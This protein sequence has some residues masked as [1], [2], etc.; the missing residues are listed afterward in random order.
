MADRDQA[1]LDRSPVTARDG[2]AMAAAAR[3]SFAR[4]QAA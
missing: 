3:A 1:D 4:S 2:E